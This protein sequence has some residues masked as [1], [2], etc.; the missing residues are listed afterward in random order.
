MR[1]ITS[2]SNPEIHNVHALKQAKERAQEQCFLA[3]G[4]RTCTTLFEYKVELVA[5]YVTEALIPT[6]NQIVPDHYPDDNIVLVSQPVMDKISSATTPSGML[7]VFRIPAQKPVAQLTNG[8]V[9]ASIADPG[10]MGTL[11]R[12]A[13]AVGVESVV[14]VEGTDPWN[15]KVVQA[16]AGMI[17]AVS[18]FKLTWQELIRHKKNKELYALVVSGGTS[19]A[20]VIPDN[21]LLVIGN[22]AHGLTGA[23]LRDCEH[24]ITLGMPGGTESLNAAVAGSIALYITF[25]QR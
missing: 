24:Q 10:N 23:Q 9:L 20:T 6:A 14:I 19:I 5:L 11:I 2:R 8:V 12:S 7:G 21:A 15:P 3:E 17:G 25:V 18:I 22:E 1:T 13:A 16:S 4:T